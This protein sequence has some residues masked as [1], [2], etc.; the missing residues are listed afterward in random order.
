MGL[1]PDSENS[2]A[3]SPPSGRGR[4]AVSIIAGAWSLFQLSLPQLITLNSDYVRAIHLVFAIVLV[5]LSFPALKKIKLGGPL[6]FLSAGDRLCLPD[7]IL[8]FAAALAAGYYALNYAGISVRQGMSVPPRDIAMG[9][10]LVVLL[11]EA[12]RR[13]LGPALSCVAGLFIAYGFLGPYMPELFAFGGLSLERMLSQLT[14]SSEGIYGVPL[15]VSA[16]TVFLFVLL[17]AMLEKSGGGQYFVQLAFSLLGR[18]KGGPAKAAVVAS[19][20]TGMVSGSSIANVVTTGTFTIPLMKRCGYPAEKACAIEVAAST[21]GQLMPPIMGAAAFIIAEYCNLSYLQVVRAAIVPAVISYLALIYI[22]HLEACKLGLRGLAVAELP[23]FG[24]VF[25]RG[26]HFL[27]PLGLLVGM[28]LT[29]FSPQ[30]AAFY[31]ILALAGLIVV[32]ELINGRHSRK[33][34]LANALRLIWQSL[35]SGGKGMMAVGVA[36]AAAGIIVGIVGMGLGEQ[37]T[38]IVDTLA[39]GNIMLILL[40]TAFASLVLGM[41]LPTT[42][43]YIVMASLTAGVIVE[44]AGEA[45]LEVPLIAAHL[46]CFFFGILADDTPPVG[47]AAYAAAAIGKANPIKTGL[48]GFAYDLRTAILPFVFIFNTDLLLWN[49]HAWWHI[50]IIFATGTIA[51]FAF[52]ALVHNYTMIRNRIHE[53]I[54]LVLCVLLLLRPQAVPGIFLRAGQVVPESTFVW[55]ALGSALF[56]S[57]YLLQW[58]RARATAELAADA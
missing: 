26:V 7:V 25:V 49:I 43:T 13:A 50:A 15:R 19:G 1:L 24:A 52:A 27:I 28:L 6:K 20:L 2:R 32:K 23:R 16:S 58:R 37:I 22:T 45:G 46:F 4:R 5:Y 10:L 9:V 18:F 44:L 38:Q 36:C 14:L 21:N 54:L 11:L 51:L 39:G 12:A 41:G 48:Q 40:L 55:Y 35:V 47:L 53:S 57:V 29:G 8:A 17:G 31:A 3:D 42:A 34:A 30:L 33:Q 56:G